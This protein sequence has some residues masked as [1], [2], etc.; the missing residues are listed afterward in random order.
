MFAIIGQY[1]HN[2]HKGAISIVTKKHK[3]SS[4]IADAFD[5]V[6]EIGADWQR[7][8]DIPYRILFWMVRRKKVFPSY[9]RSLALRGANNLMQFN[10]LDRIKVWDKNDTMRNLDVPEDEHVTIPSI[11]IIELFTPNQAESLSK[12][13]KKN[14]WNKKSR[15]FPETNT[16]RLAEARTKNGLSWW[17]LANVVSKNFS[18]MVS[19]MTRSD[20][21]EGIQ[22]INMRAVQ[23]GTGLT[24]VTARFTFDKDY[25]EHVD[26]VW[27]S[28]HEPRMEYVAGRPRPLDRQFA[29]L[30]DTQTSR[31]ELHKVARIWMADHLPGYF[32]SHKEEQLSLDIILTDRYDPTSKSV[33]PL[34]R[35]LSDAYR[36]LGVDTH[37]FNTIIAPQLP[38]ML[39]AQAGERSNRNINRNRTWGLIGNREKL[40]KSTDN[41]KY[42]GGD[43]E[44]AVS[45][46]VGDRLG[47]TLILLAVS[48]LLSIIEVQYAKLRDQ[49]SR[50]HSRFKLRSIDRLGSIVL[51]S[52]LTLASIKH[53]VTNFKESG[54]WFKED[55][56]FE[57]AVAPYFKDKT[58]NKKSRLLFD[59][60]LKRQDKTLE[61]LTAID[62]DYKD[63]LVT[64]STLKSTSNSTKISRNAFWV[65]L[66][67]LVVAGIALV[68]A[69]LSYL[70][71]TVPPQ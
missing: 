24:A 67:S 53:E 59:D 41:F 30:K 25:A 69:Y 34:D 71:Q 21:P 1:S 20:L 39:L 23:I 45:S 50:Q 43:P 4:F 38:D 19:D 9:L 44:W 49:A 14:G 51:D 3:T 65:A 12:S 61:R 68:I 48:E 28:K 7:W 10:E 70:A 57:V 22:W 13:I 31:N 27:H 63:I 29:G 55:A 5:E 8:Y 6:P 56:T 58:K 33:K 66:I 40:Q 26:S 52:S 16:E 11:M 60:I 37:D 18:G 17:I 32:A 62:R 2:C 42:Y 64:V 46:I 15:V 36:A 47:T 54:W 35:G